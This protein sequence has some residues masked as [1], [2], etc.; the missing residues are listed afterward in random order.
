MAA[1][2]LHELAGTRT[3]W[4]RLN[5]NGVNRPDPADRICLNGESPVVNSYPLKLY[6][7]EHSFRMR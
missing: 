2:T 3:A 1:A 6:K 4:R 7:P 5:H